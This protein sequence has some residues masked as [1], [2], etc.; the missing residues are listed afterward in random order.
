MT[1]FRGEALSV[2]KRFPFFLVLVSVDAAGSGAAGS[3]HE[4][5]SV[6]VFHQ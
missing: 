6:F 3:V 1:L 5:S 4:V 2:E